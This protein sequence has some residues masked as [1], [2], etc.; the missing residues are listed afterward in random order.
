MSVFSITL[1][2]LTKEYYRELFADI[3][4]DVGDDGN[5]NAE[6]IIEA[7]QEA[8]DDWHKYHTEAAGRFS[9]MRNLSNRLKVNQEN[10]F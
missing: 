8:I 9:L 5:P 6:M 1:M 10:N 4:G 2:I 7:F 3:V